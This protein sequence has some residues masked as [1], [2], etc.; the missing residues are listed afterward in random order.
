MLRLTLHPGE[1]RAVVGAIST[2]RRKRGSMS[3][4]A[5]L[6]RMCRVRWTTRPLAVGL[7]VAGLMVGA[8]GPAD[9]ASS[10]GVQPPCPPDGSFYNTYSQTISNAN[11]RDYYRL[12]ERPG[13]GAIAN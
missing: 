8:A 3:G 11:P 6:S 7:A 4:S 2:R 1:T 5:R 12:G 10:D 9:A 13:G